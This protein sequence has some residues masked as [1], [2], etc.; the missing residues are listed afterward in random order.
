MPNVIWKQDFPVGETKHFNLL[1]AG[2]IPPT[3][4]SLGSEISWYD[5]IFTLAGTWVRTEEMLDIIRILDTH[6]INT[7]KVDNYIFHSL[8]AGWARFVYFR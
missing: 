2:W 5:P 1:I 3:Y 7:V 8:L 6:G 4:F